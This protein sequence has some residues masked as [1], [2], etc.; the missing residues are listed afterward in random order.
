M[1][2]KDYEKPSMRVITL[3]HRIGFLCQS[4]VTSAKGVS[5]VSNSEGIGFAG[6][7]DDSYTDN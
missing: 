4:P 5:S 7:M 1:N 2:K 6:S 3:K